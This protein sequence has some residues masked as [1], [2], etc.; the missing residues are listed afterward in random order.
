[1]S[2]RSW[3]SVLHFF[4]PSSHSPSV[5]SVTCDKELRSNNMEKKSD[6]T[7]QPTGEYNTTHAYCM[8]YNKGYRHAPR[9][10]NNYCFSTET[11]VTRTRLYYV[12]RALPVWLHAEDGRTDRQRQGEL[13][14]SICTTSIWPEEGARMKLAV[15]V[16]KCS[17]SYENVGTRPGNKLY[18][19]TYKSS[20]SADWTMPPAAPTLCISSA[21]CFFCV[22]SQD[23]HTK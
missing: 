9:I 6:A 10:C 3:R 11:M 5:W 13:N 12:I 22:F 16:A 17:M 19:H 15:E 21:V 2:W 1:V 14:R 20:A 4:R 7:W 18:P 8:L 23:R